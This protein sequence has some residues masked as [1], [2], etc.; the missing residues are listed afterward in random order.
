[1]SKF[2]KTADRATELF[3]TF[4][5]RYFNAIVIVTWTAVLAM[6]IAPFCLL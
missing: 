6:M 2:V 3:M 4:C 1:M 5:D